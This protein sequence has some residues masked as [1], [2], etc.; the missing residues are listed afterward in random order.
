[1]LILW[2]VNVLLEQKIRDVMP[3]VCLKTPRVAFREDHCIL[4]RGVGRCWKVME[5]FSMGF[6][7]DFLLEDFFTP[8]KFNMEPENDGFQKESSFPGVDFQ[9]PC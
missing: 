2:R 6:G 1:M 7:G 8:P 4:F 3:A 9:V 5:E